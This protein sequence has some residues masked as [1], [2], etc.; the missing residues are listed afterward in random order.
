LVFKAREHAFQLYLQRGD[1]RGAG[2][3]ATA[4]AGDYLQFRGEAAVAR[5]W[6]RRAHRLLEGLRPAPEHGWLQVSEAD[7]TL[8]SGGDPASVRRHAAR[9]AAV[10]RSAGAVDLE[11]VA[12][13]LEGLALVTE[14]KRAQGLDCLDEASAAAMSGEMTDRMA[15]GICCCYVVTAC[16]RIRDFDRAAQWCAR[17]KDFCEA[18]HFKALLGMCRAQ[19]G[20]VLVWRGWWAEADTELTTAARQL[21]ATRPA[22]Q[23]DALMRLAELRRHQGRFD[24][25]R[26]LLEGT[27]A[28]PLTALARAALALDAQP[29]GERVHGEAARGEHPHKAGPSIS[30]GRGG[31]R[32]AARPAV[33]GPAG[34][35]GPR[36]PPPAA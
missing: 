27:V 12:L 35:I 14:G 22:M 34:L 19:Y 33:A 21:A 17:L 36:R 4:L 13:A 28:H 18:T 29:D 5:G 2:R 10:G 15:I 25:A 20:G 32:G 8:A 30:G 23:A 16:E 11:M 6:H 7:L 3:L 24:E 31:I 9:A 1:R 26:R